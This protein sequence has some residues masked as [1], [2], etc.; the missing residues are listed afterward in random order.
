MERRINRKTNINWNWQF[1]CCS[2]PKAQWGLV[3]KTVEPLALGQ[4]GHSRAKPWA[5]E[6][7][8]TQTQ[9]M[10]EVTSGV[11]SEGWRDRTSSLWTLVYIVITLLFLLLYMHRVSLTPPCFFIDIDYEHLEYV[12]L[13]AGWLKQDNLHRLRILVKGG[14][15]PGEKM[16]IWTSTNPRHMI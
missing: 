10:Q 16:E 14:I 15:N 4:T 13:Y 6:T 8:H 2:S 3:V 5:V 7:R 1:H 12:N 9:A 11:I